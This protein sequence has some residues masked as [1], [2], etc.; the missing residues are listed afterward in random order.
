MQPSIAIVGRGRLG[1]ALARALGTPAPLGRGADPPHAGVVLLCVPD[2]EIDAAAAAVPPGPLVGHC[3]GA[4]PLG[5]CDLSVHPLMT[6]TADTPPERFAGAGCAVAGRDER[7]LAVARGIAERLGMTAIAVPDEDRAAYHAG[8]SLAANYLVTL[9]DAAERVF[10]HDR[11]L[12]AP[13]ARAALENWVAGGRAALTGPVARGDRETV[14]RQR[15][16][17]AR[18]APELLDVWDAMTARTEAIA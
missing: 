13:L 2:A 1:R 12:L 17:V 15:A 5:P 8:A 10:G 16:A 11:A 9:E 4:R 7:A 18:R 3:S 14:A 6:V